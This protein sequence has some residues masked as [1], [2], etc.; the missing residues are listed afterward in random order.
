MSRKLCLL[1]VLMLTVAANVAWAGIP[2]TES[3][4]TQGAIDVKGAGNETPLTQAAS[5]LTW[6]GYNN[7][8]TTNT[9]I[10]NIQVV[11][12]GI[13]F[14]GRIIG[15]G[16]G[17]GSYFYTSFLSS[18]NMSNGATLDFMA[19]M[20]KTGYA[21]TGVKILLRASGD[22][23]LSNT[24]VDIL[25]DDLFSG[26]K[27]AYS[28]DPA[29]DTT[30]DTLDATTAAML[31]ALAAGDEA[32]VKGLGTAINLT[33]TELADVTG[34]GFLHASS[35]GDGNPKLQFDDI[36]WN[37]DPTMN[38]D[39][40]VT[41]N[42]GSTD[43]KYAHIVAL[44]GGDTYPGLN[45]IPGETNDG[46]ENITDAK[47]TDA[48]AGDTL[49]YTWTVTD[50]VG[51]EDWATAIGDVDFIREG[52]N[53]GAGANAIDPNI[54]YKDMGTYTVELTVD[55]GEDTD[56]AILTQHVVDNRA[57]RIAGI[58]GGRQRTVYAGTTIE[59]LNP[60][61]RDDNYPLSVAK[62]WQ[63]MRVVSGPASLTFHY[64][65]SKD[66]DSYEGIGKNHPILTHEPQDP[67][68][69]IPDVVGF[70][71]IR[72]HAYDGDLYSWQSATDPN[73]LVE[74]TV[75]DNKAMTDVDAGEDQIA[76][77]L[78]GGQITLEGSI[79]DPDPEIDNK[80]VA[81]YVDEG[82]SGVDISL[83]VA[84][85]STATFD[86]L[87]EYTLRLEVTEV[88][89]ST[90]TI[91]ESDTMT[92]TVF[93]AAMNTAELVPEDDASVRNGSNNYGA[94][95]S[96]HISAKN[97]RQSY[98]QFDLNQI[99]GNIYEAYLEVEANGE[100][101][102][103][104][105]C[106]AVTYGPSGDWD[107]GTGTGTVTDDGITGDND[108]LVVGDLL[109]RKEV[110]WVE[111]DRKLFDVMDMVIESDRKVTFKVDMEY[112]ADG[113]SDNDAF[114]SKENSDNKA[115]PPENGPK[116]FLTYD[117]NQAYWP[118]PAE[119][120]VNTV[121]QPTL[122]WKLN[123]QTSYLYLATSESA[124]DAMVTPTATV[125]N[126]PN[127][128]WTPPSMLTFG[129]EYWWRID[130]DNNSV[131]E[132]WKFNVMMMN[133]A[134]AITLTPNPLDVYLKF[135]NSLRS[136]GSDADKAAVEAKGN[137]VHMVASA[138][139]TDEYPNP[140]LTYTWTQ[141]SG[142]G[143][144]SFDP[145]NDPNTF[146]TLSEPG[147]YEI[148]FQADD[149]EDIGSEIL[150]INAMWEPLPA[151]GPILPSDDAYTRSSFGETG[152]NPEKNNGARDELITKHNDDPT[153]GGH[154]RTYLKFDLSSIVGNIEIA[155]L[156]LE[157]DGG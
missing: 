31:D 57:P 19:E 60:T 30:W 102:Q 105:L 56:T 132:N 53:D 71:E 15:S 63:H 43:V 40:V 62:V 48:D 104:T 87:G 16:G 75:I 17:P 112:R 74:L 61:V 78:A 38:V 140:I 41:I 145:D 2:V 9:R 58:D 92:V 24:P 32:D 29:A 94:A 144:A 10:V 77:L 49:T 67:N 101:D 126:D 124:L 146:I 22:W 54:W 69:I 5:G 130:G 21:P 147:T 100:I 45:F 122:K 47:A 107:E 46:W 81:W 108:D 143:T 127:G 153:N 149:G 20:N 79:T 138:V 148:L 139:D 51:P 115:T 68:I 106:W 125:S 155:T 91:V 82:P 52:G 117:P 76:S 114:R 34:G 119:D 113:T 39:P 93:P 134:P 109:E 33:N 28:F 99:P 14:H 131:G 42:G 35:P 4:G 98:I 84:L 73:R 70:Y 66:V 55:D 154:Y 142:P 59:G 8:I 83:P 23:Y 103:N 80:T 95:S 133:T 141:L 12:G 97:S 111:K 11:S 64:G 121:P 137:K 3:F 136:V 88:S 85:D 27:K 26:T 6:G 128:T 116:L 1:T 25:D 36:V 13:E 151:S 110:T 156:E 123:S 65:D 37:L 150:T 90:G 18:L 157:A 44:S 72:V 135:D 118:S 50:Y 89:D 152:D 86:T 96:L 129:Q 120:A 7:Y